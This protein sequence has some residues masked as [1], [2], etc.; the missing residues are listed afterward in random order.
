VDPATRF[1]PGAH[2]MCATEAGAAAQ[3]DRLQDEQNFLDRRGRDKPAV[4]RRDKRNCAAGAWLSVFPNRLNGTGLSADEWRDNVRLRYNHSPLE[5]PAACDGCGAKMTVEHALSCKTGRLVHIRQDDVADEWRHLCRTALSPCRVEREPS[6][7]SSISRQVRN[8]AG[9]SAPDSSTP[10]ADALRPPAAATE[11]W[12][13]ASCHGFWEHGRTYLI[14]VLRTRTLNPTARRN[15][16]KFLNSMR[17]RRRRSI[18]R[19]V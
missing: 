9:A 16:Q 1:D 15:L 3:R 4:A 19:T 17:R 10:T 18:S 12:G 2:R 11:E 5:M 14:C 7:F 8:A 6:I 13:D